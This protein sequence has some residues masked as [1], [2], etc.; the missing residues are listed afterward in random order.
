MSRIHDFVSSGKELLEP[1]HMYRIPS[2]ESKCQLFTL[3]NEYKITRGFRVLETLSHQ[4]N[5][6]VFRQISHAINVVRH[7]KLKDKYT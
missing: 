7:L 1:L 6:S 3:I 5:V 2:I 4:S